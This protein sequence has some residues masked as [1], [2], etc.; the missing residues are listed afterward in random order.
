M[1]TEDSD[2]QTNFRKYGPWGALAFALS[3]LVL[4]VTSHFDDIRKLTPGLDKDKPAAT[5]QN[6]FPPAIHVETFQ[7]LRP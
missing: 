7:F 6:F 5:V 1:P 4:F 2:D 3:A